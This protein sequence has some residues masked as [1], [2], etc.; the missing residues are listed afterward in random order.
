[1][2]HAGPADSKADPEVQQSVEL[3]QKLYVHESILENSAIK[4]IKFLYFID[5]ARLN[6]LNGFFLDKQL[7]EDFLLDF[8]ESNRSSNIGTLGTGA[9]I[10][11]ASIIADKVRRAPVKLVRA[12]GFGV[13]FALTSSFYWTSRFS[14][15]LMNYYTIAERVDD[16]F[17]QQIKK[18]RTEYCLLHGLD[19]ASIKAKSPVSK[20]AQGGPPR[21]NNPP[22]PN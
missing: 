16:G 5:V 8:A 7:T 15:Q 11:L 2:S 3:F 13:P 4:G 14:G 22:S 21:P 18:K 20:P 1:M 9:G 19:E 12:L 10:T 6:S 17:V